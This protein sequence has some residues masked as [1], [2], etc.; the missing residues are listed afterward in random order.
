ML[1]L[2]FSKL[3]CSLAL[4]AHWRS[5]RICI[6]F[7]PCTH[8]KTICTTHFHEVPFKAKYEPVQNSCTLY[9][10]YIIELKGWP[11]LWNLFL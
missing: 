10:I 1:D 2:Q 11:K 9:D 4:E 5:G 6:P 3:L 7:T 8:R